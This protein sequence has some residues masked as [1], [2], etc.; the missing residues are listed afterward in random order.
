MTWGVAADFVNLNMTL[1]PLCCQYSWF[2]TSVD[3]LPLLTQ[4][5]TYAVEGGMGNSNFPQKA[6]GINSQTYSHYHTT[7]LSW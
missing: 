2:Q 7:T 3:V 4:C 5:E 1:G 6:T